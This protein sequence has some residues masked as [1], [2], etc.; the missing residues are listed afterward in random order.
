MI[1]RKF[2]DRAAG[3]GAILAILFSVG[4]CNRQD[5][6]PRADTA[7][8]QP[9][10]PDAAPP[11]ATTP[12]PMTPAPMSPAGEASAP[13][14]MNGSSSSSSQP[15]TG[16]R[17]ELMPD[18]SL[19][20]ARSL[21][22]SSGMLVRTAEGDLRNGSASSG[23]SWSSD[24]GMSSSAQ[25]KSSRRS[26]R[27]A[28]SSRASSGPARRDGGQSSSPMGRGS[29]SSAG[30]SAP[31]PDSGGSGTGTGTGTGTGSGAGTGSGSGTQGGAGNSRMKAHGRDLL[32]GG[33]I[34]VAD[35][36]ASSTGSANASKGTKLG[37]SDRNFVEKAAGAGL[38]EVEAARI[39]V[40]RASAPGV[41]SFAQMLVVQHTAAND[42]LKQLVSMRSNVELPTKLP[43]T[44]RMALE[45][46]QRKSG[47]DFDREFIEQVGIE[48]HEDDIKLFEKA[49]R[50]AEDSEV[51]AWAARKLPVLRQHLAAA[52]RLPGEGGKSA[53]GADAGT[54]S[55]AG[56]QPPSD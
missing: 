15:G 3:I 31:S 38:Y 25:T 51:R 53:T 47:K 52:R 39:A 7:P 43:A 11:T 28:T 26:S 41:K 50:D 56:A 16:L 18:R 23:G 40:E 49:S 4:G 1:N 19:A 21:D 48:D 45:S 32:W 6:T 46:L 30:S 5:S 24:A 2:I 13:A 55:R 33:L 54:P 10:T 22:H 37:N 44:K 35:S 14:S 27:G 36:A 17:K 9:T 20:L 34:R 8:M 12:A 29:G 42:E